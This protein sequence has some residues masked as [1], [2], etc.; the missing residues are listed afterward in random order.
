MK[1]SIQR[2]PSFWS[3]RMRNTSSA[4][5]MHA[6]LERDAEQEIEADRCADHFGQVGGADGEFGE[7]PERIGD[8]AREGI[9]AGLGEIAPRATPSRAQ[10]DCRMIA[11]MLERSAMKSSA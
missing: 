8:P 1:A 7:H 9:A 11:M 10:S 6:D 5:R 2:K 3:H 4:V